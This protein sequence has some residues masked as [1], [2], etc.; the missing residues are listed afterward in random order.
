MKRQISGLHA[1]DCCAIDQ[2]PDGFF[3][4]RL[5]RVKFQRQAQKP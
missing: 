2:I 3:L 1:A 5:Q 4:V